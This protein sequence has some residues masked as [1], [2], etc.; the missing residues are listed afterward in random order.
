MKKRNLLLL[1]YCVPYAFLA[2]YG[3]EAFGSVLGYVLLIAGAV[4][5]GWLCGKVEGAPFWWGNAL[6][7]AISLLCTWVVYGNRMNHYFKPFSAVGLAAV[8]SA[9]SLG[10]QWLVKKRQWLVL[11]LASGAVGLML[12]VM[13][14]LQWSL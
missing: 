13:Y 1:G 7:A 5:L 12:L 2:L 3:D 9:V 6:T 10:I 4:I 14:S 8:L 11:G